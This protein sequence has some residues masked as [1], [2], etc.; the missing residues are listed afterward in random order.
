[1]LHA[2]LAA[3]V[4]SSPGAGELV[5][6]F[7]FAVGF[8]TITDVLKWLYAFLAWMASMVMAPIITAGEW[9]EALGAYAWAWIR[10]AGIY[11]FNLTGWV[12]LRAADMWKVYIAPFLG[13]LRFAGQLAEAYL[14]KIGDRLLA[15]LRDVVAG[16]V[17]GLVVISRYGATTAELLGGQLVALRGAGL[18]LAALLDAQLYAA[19]LSAYTGASVLRTAVNQGTAWVNYA[20]DA[21]G[22]LRPT[23]LSHSIADAL[24]EVWAGLINPAISPTIHEDVDALTRAMPPRTIGM[25]RA[26]AVTGKIATDPRVLA[27]LARLVAGIGAVS[28]PP[29]A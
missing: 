14:L 26:D 1:M 23:V 7:S 18:K 3:V 29:G 8:W 6:L 19:A 21:K 22:V 9:F 25:V 20:L 10:A 4:P 27:A 12:V 16:S 13:T 17:L 11:T 2:L 24:G 28:T 5:L 15:A